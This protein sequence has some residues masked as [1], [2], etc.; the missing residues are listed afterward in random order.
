MDA[1]DSNLHP[2]GIRESHCSLPF[3]PHRCG[4]RELT[5]LTSAGQSFQRLRFRLPMAITFFLV[6]SNDWMRRGKS[7]GINEAV[8][9]NRI[10]SIQWGTAWLKVFPEFCSGFL[11]GGGMRENQSWMRRRIAACGKTLSMDSFESAWLQPR[12]KP[13]KRRKAT[14][15][16]ARPQRRRAAHFVVFPPTVS[17]PRQKYIFP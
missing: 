15:E 4:R 7:V 2:E 3:P 9:S 10:S 1:A 17:N 13:F 12:R 11:V 6:F 8:D 16:T 14:L 5:A